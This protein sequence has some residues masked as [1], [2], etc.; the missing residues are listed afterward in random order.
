LPVSRGDKM[1]SLALAATAPSMIESF[2]ARNKPEI[3]VL[4]LAALAVMLI[5][6]GLRKVYKHFKK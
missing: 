3:A 4:C 1:D 5:I 6:L 2:E